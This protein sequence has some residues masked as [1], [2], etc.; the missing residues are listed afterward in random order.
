[1][2]EFPR[3]SFI[4]L[5]IMNDFYRELF[6]FERHSLALIIWSFLKKFSEF[7]K[8]PGAFLYKG[9]KIKTCLIIFLCSNSLV[10]DL[11][12]PIEKSWSKKYYQKGFLILFQSTFF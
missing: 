10:K 7:R 1:M 8:N 11:I 12:I 2:T 4:T 3:R 9:L 5:K 6:S